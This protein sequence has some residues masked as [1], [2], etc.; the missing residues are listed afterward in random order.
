VLLVDGRCCDK[1]ATKKVFVSTDTGK[2][3]GPVP[4]Q[5][6]YMDGPGDNIAGGAIYAAAGSVGRP[7][8]S[9]L[10]ISDVQTIGVTFQATGT[11]S[12]VESQTANLGADSGASYQGSLAL[13]GTGTLVATFATLDKLYWSKWKGGVLD[14]NAVANWTPAALLDATNVNSTAKLV[15]GPSGIYVSYG[16]GSPGSERF[17]LRKFNGTGWGAALRLTEIGSPNNGDLVEDA[18]GVLH[19]AW[20]DTRGRLRY[21]YA[22]SAANVDFTRAQ[23]LAGPNQNFYPLKLAANNA[24]RGWITWEQSGA[25]KV[26]PVAPGEPPPPPYSG[27]TTTKSKSVAGD[28]LVLTYPKACVTVPQVF[29]AKVA[30]EA[31]NGGGVK[32]KIK[33]VVFSRDGKPVGTDTTKPFKLNVPTTGLANGTSHTLEAK[34][35]VEFKKN[36]SNQQTDKTLKA[37]FSTC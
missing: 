14:V 18:S 17:V 35:T 22:R 9:I 11:G 20:Q 30:A 1:Y 7:A 12:D 28:K 29:A 31:K 13:Q 4:N 21:R 36:G 2:T 24:G 19:F 6:G 16:V 10:T 23:K 27:P 3:F 34:V 25:I 8:E 33:K 5:P 15:S 32:I 37:L 26:I